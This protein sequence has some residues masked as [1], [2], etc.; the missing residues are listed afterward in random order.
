MVCNE[1]V[2]D[3]GIKCDRCERWA[4][5]VSQGGCCGLSAPTFDFLAKNEL[6]GIKWFCPKCVDEKGKCR[7]DSIAEQSAKLETLTTIV[8]TLQQQ[9]KMILDLLSKERIIK[10]EDR[11]KVQVSEALESQKEKD[12][13]ATNLM[14][15]NVVETDIVEDGIT[16]KEDETTHDTASVANIFASVD[17]EFKND[18]IVSI[19]RLGRRKSIN[20]PKSGP[21]P[22]KV[23]LKNTKQRDEILKNAWRL[24]DN[25][26][27][28]KTGISPDETIKER[29]ERKALRKELLERREKGEEVAIFQGKIVPKTRRTV[30]KLP[31][32]SKVIN[33]DQDVLASQDDEGEVFVSPQSSL[34]AK[35][36]DSH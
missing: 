23:T 12:T 34:G 19:T 13:R 11:I 31:A 18:N 6:E 2:T 1:L 25:P 10:N 26:N 24:K 4:H 14:V 20:E 15:F 21:R 7:E 5:G 27:F 30:S 3:E 29:N 35:S 28:K 32:E 16:K 9:N 33:R 17:R 8:V 36:G 22:I